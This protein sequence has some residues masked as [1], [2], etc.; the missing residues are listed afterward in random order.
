MAEKKDSA[1]DSSHFDDYDFESAPLTRVTRTVNSDFSLDGPDSVT[2]VHCN[3]K[4][5]DVS[6]PLSL[7]V[8]N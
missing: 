2:S 8:Q 5:K 1:A 4:D 3:K 7:S 6:L